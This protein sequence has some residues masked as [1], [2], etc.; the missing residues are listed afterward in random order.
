M[1]KFYITTSIAYTNAPPHIGFALESIQADVLARYHRSL[2]EDVFFLTGVDE[3]GLKIAK[4]AKEEGK[5]PKKFVNEISVKFIDLKNTLNLS[6]DYFIRTTDKKNHWPG[7]FKIWQKLAEKRDIY[8]KNY[9]GLYCVGC[10]AFK[11]KRE[12]VGGKCPIHK[13][14]PEEV[15]EENYFF[16]LSKYE[17][18]IK[19]AL[20]KN[21]IKI[22]PESRK[23][24]MMSFIEQGL[25]DVSFSRPAENLKWGIPVPGDSSQTI[26]VWADALTNYLSALGYGKNETNFKKYWPA[27]V[28]CIGKDIQK[29]HILIWPAMLLSAGLELP[30]KIFVHGFI[31]SEGQKISKSLGNVVDPFELVKKYGTDAVRYFLLA[32]IPSTED[33]DFSYKRFEERYNGDLAAGIGNLI[34]RVNAMAAKSNYNFKILNSKQILNSKFKNAVK[35]TE[36]K[37]KKALEDFKFN[38][39]LKA[40]WELIG[41]C[42]RYIDQEKPW[43][44]KNEKLKLKNEKVINDLLFALKN[45]AG[46]LTPFLPET[47]EKILKNE[48]GTQLFPRIDRGLD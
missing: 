39:A 30:E 26:Y 4:R 22:I 8:K 23:N 42:D 29:F 46:F 43:D 38:E 14:K 32:E 12:L 16:K 19:N 13:T 36:V 44:N 2:K 40:V 5:S 24:E 25:E 34:S 18:E 35:Q 17:K 37:Y 28:H 11:T 21:K 7:V 6:S 9:E 27:N 31:T 1:K 45:I 10:E 41:F 33:G 15:S 20:K 47:S 48:T 3:H